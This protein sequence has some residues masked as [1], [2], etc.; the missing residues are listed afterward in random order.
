MIAM[1]YKFVLPSDYPMTSIENRIKDKGHLLNGCEG[2]VFKAYLYSRK[3]TKQYD[4]SVNSYAPFYVWRD[5][6]AMVLFLKSDGFKALCD[7]FG[8]PRVDIWFI[9]EAPTTP[10]PSH[11]FACVNKCAKSNTDVHGVDYSSW[12][13]VDVTWLSDSKEMNGGDIYRVGYIAHGNNVVA[14]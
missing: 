12:E 6:S 4:N 5:H 1:H 13:S 3:D 14:K 9:D 11:S 10:S 8:R 7:Q 2:L